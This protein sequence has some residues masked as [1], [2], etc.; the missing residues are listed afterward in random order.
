MPA[1]SFPL[2]IRSGLQSFHAKLKQIEIYDKI[3]NNNPEKGDILA[4]HEFGIM[5]NA[6][7]Q[8]KRYDDY[9]PWEYDCISVDD[10][11][12]EGIDN[13]LCRI[14]FYW[15]TLDV[16]G[17]GIAYCGVTLIPPCSVKAFI[18]VIKD[19][20]ELSNLKALLEKAHSENKWIIHF[21]L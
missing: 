6:P 18:D 7:Q 19:I 14:D 2:S 11:H 4:R 21:G 15:H 13:H 5:Q 9:V 12:L 1:F 3:R 16:K 8:G 20:S 10:G 17:K